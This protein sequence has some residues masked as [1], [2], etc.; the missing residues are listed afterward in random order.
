MSNMQWS[1]SCDKEYLAIFET[2]LILQKANCKCIFYSYLHDMCFAY[3]QH[4]GKVWPIVHF[5][6]DQIG[7]K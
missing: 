6:N 3:V 4:F 7:V 2:A 5:Y 1:N